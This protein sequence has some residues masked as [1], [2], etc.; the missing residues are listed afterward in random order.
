MASDRLAVSSDQTVVRHRLSRSPKKVQDVEYCRFY[1]FCTARP[2]GFL[3]MF[4]SQFVIALHPGNF[5]Q[6]L[7]RKN[8]DS[9]ELRHPVKGQFFLIPLRCSFRIAFRQ[10]NISGQVQACGRQPMMT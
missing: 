10:G 7:Q 4:C 1:I 8:T 5:A 6:P 9:F 2:Q 3:K